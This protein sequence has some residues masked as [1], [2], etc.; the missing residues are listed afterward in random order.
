LKKQLKFGHFLDEKLK[1]NLLRQV[2]KF[3]SHN[4][5]FLNKNENLRSKVLK[6]EGLEI[7]ELFKQNK[8]LF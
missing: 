4:N 3:T 1:E 8:K 7:R 2:K 6:K 5:Q